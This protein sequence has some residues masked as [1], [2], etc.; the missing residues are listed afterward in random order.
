MGSLTPLPMR[1]WLRI[2]LQAF[3]SL[4]CLLLQPFK[5]CISRRI[6]SIQPAPA[7]FNEYVVDVVAIEQEHISKG[8]PVLVLVVGL[9]ERRYSA[10][11]TLCLGQSVEI[12]SPLRA[13]WCRVWDVDHSFALRLPLPCKP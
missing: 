10:I 4:S 5:D 8:A 12:W 3:H 11:G 2:S 6:L 1:H 13:R 7:V 9:E